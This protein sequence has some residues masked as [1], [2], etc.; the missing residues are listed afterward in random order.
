[1]RLSPRQSS[2]PGDEA[3]FRTEDVIAMLAEEFKKASIDVADR[4]E[5]GVESVEAFECVHW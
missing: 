4:E 1:M 5:R 3:A 2:V